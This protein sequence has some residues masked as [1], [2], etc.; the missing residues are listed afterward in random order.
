MFNKDINIYDAIYLN[1]HVPKDVSFVQ[2]ISP[3]A[4]GVKSSQQPGETL[5]PSYR[6]LLGVL[7]CW[8]SGE[9]HMGPWFWY[10]DV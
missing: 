9:A 4:R 2:R 3:V 7:G 10:D 6:Q 8:L 1:I 5:A